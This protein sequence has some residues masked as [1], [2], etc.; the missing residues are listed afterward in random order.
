MYMYTYI[1]IYIYT[2]AGPS[3]PGLCRSLPVGQGVRAAGWTG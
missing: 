2:Y 3:N 1:Y